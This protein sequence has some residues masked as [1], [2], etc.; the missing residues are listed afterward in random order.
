ME[1]P[2]AA[3]GPRLE[4]EVR[5]PRGV[6]FCFFLVFLRGASVK[7]TFRGHLGVFLRGTRLNMPI[8]RGQYAT[9]GRLD[10]AEGMRTAC[11]AQAKWVL[12]GENENVTVQRPIDFTSQFAQQLRLKSPR[13]LIFLAVDMYQEGQVVQAQV[14]QAGSF[15]LSIS[16]LTPAWR[17][18][19]SCMRLL[20]FAV[21]ACISLYQLLI[22]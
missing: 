22:P 20:S 8:E 14:V 9:T 11:P 13:S 6:R 21:S 18:P 3:P 1:L 7:P 12:Q 17:Q 4:A 5:L 15:A 2:E 19:H 16:R 10:V